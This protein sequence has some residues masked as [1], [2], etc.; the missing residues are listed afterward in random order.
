MSLDKRRQNYSNRIIYTLH[1]Y[2][3]ILYV[4]RVIVFAAIPSCVPN[5]ASQGSG[6]SY[7]LN[8]LWQ[9]ESDARRK[10]DFYTLLTIFFLCL[11]IERM[12]GGEC[13]IRQV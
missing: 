2:I 12:L 8:V 11:E 9:M 3:Y 5:K 13:T 10:N 4:V 1:I 6:P 7:E